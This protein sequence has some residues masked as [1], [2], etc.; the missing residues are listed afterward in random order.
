[1]LKKLYT[2]F[3]KRYKFKF[4]YLIILTLIVALLEMLSMGLII[5]I[6]YF[7]FNNQTSDIYLVNIFFEF[8]IYLA[9]FFSVDDLIVLFFLVFLTFLIKFMVLL[10]FVFFELCILRINKICNFAM[11]II[12]LKN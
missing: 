4:F 9:K 6:A 7:F 8:V 10:Y 2:L 1:M 11:E 3:D 5:P 12:F